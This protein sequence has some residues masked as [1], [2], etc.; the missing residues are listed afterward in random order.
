MDKP[1][2]VLDIDGVL[3]EFTYS[4][5]QVMR[6]LHQDGDYDLH[7]SGGQQS[8]GWED[9]PEEVVS[10]TWASIHVTPSFWSTLAVIPSI[11]EV[12][13]LHALKNSVD[14]LYLTGRR[15]DTRD[16][17][18]DWLNEMDFPEGKLILT[19][20]KHIALQRHDT[21]AL[22]ILE[23]SPANIELLKKFGF[24]V[25]I[26]DWPYNRE[27]GGVTRVSSLGEFIQEV[28]ARLW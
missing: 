14:F 17:T 18:A 1:L 8:W 27:V 15:T 5:C 9:I 2:V 20:Q 6:M 26:R 16:V 23:D 4:F 10:R 11:P 19:N 12:N 3:A 24:P 21:E 7:T 22:A 28:K 13:G 25:F